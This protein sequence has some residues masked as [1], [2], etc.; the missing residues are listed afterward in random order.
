MFYDI[1]RVSSVFLLSFS[2]TFPGQFK[3][4]SG[5]IPGQYY[6][7]MRI[8]FADFCRNCGPWG[9]LQIATINSKEGAT[10]CLSVI[11]GLE[12]GSRFLSVSLHLFP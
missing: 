2:R 4:K 12:L 7:H 6:T 8:F 5:K 10:A 1:C 9:P 11:S 3:D